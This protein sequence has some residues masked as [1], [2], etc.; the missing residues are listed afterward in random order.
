MGER[1]IYLDNAATTPLHPRALEAMLPYL[2]RSYGN[3]SA[4]YGLAKQAGDAVQRCRR[5]VASIL[6]CRPTE[7]IFT[8]GG[9]ESINT[10]IKGVAFQQKK[11][12]AGNHIVTS[13]I[14]HHAVLHAC[15][16]LERFGFEV[17]YVPVDA[18]GLIDPADVAVAV[19]ERTVLVSIMTANNEVGTIEPVFEI[20]AAVRARAQALRKRIPF[21]TDAVQAPNSLSMN[22]ADHGIDLLSLAAHKFRGPKGMG[23][24]YIRKG[25]PF[26]AQM[27]GGGQERQRRAGTEN[28][29]GIVGTTEALWITQQGLEA[30][31]ARIGALSMRL[32]QGILES[33]SGSRLNGHPERRLVNNVSVSFDGADARDLVAA[34]D[35]EG[36]ACSAGAACGATTVEPSHVLLALDIPLER[37][38]ATLRFSIGHETTDAD[39]DYVLERLPGAVAR[40]REAQH[41]V[42]AGA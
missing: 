18:D 10:A 13:T 11:A 26:L 22:F 3:P 21:H 2:T 6:G 20:A 7:V 36:I 30:D 15:Q 29:A 27:N 31:R 19:N 28:V 42:V 9:T 24:L 25:V 4:T 5:T 34:L 33:M 41:A 38:V 16:Y 39:I 14:E 40:S 17:T 32:R 1:L 8:G 23:V 35:A 12:R 37:A